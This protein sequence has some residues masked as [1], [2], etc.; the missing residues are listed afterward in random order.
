MEVPGIEEKHIDVRIEGNTLALQGERKLEKDEKE[1]NHRRIERQYESFTRSFTL[2]SVVDPSQLSAHCDK[3]ALKVD[4]AKKVESKPKQI[5]VNV[6]SEK[7]LDARFTARL[8]K[9]RQLVRKLGGGLDRF[10]YYHLDVVPVA[11]E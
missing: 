2:P 8:P 11:R 5:K 10:F 7:V 1:E 9:G 6:G 4:L 3:G